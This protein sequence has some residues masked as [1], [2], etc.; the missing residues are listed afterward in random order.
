LSTSISKSPADERFE[1][2]IVFFLIGIAYIGSI[3]WST[4]VDE[5]K[6]PFSA[7]LLPCWDLSDS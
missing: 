4:I 3:I 5:S 1:L 6:A 2:D 7:A